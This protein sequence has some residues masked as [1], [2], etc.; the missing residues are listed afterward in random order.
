MRARFVSFESG[1]V[2]REA[3][4]AVKMADNDVRS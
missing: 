1:S 4:S 2:A 3:L